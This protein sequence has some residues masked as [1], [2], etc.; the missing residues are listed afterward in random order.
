MIHSC[1]VLE[2]SGTQSNRLL[3]PPPLPY[4]IVSDLTKIMGVVEILMGIYSGQELLEPQNLGEK[5]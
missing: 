3:A 5:A 1:Q 2:S 4:V